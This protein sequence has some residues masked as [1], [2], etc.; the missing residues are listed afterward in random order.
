MTLPCATAIRDAVRRTGGLT[1]VA[2]DLQP[3]ALEHGRAAPGPGRG[4]LLLD[5]L[6]LHARGAARV[7]RCVPGPPAQP[8]GSAGLTSTCWSSPARAATRWS[9]T[10]RA[11]WRARRPRIR[12]SRSALGAP[13][14]LPRGVL[15][16][17]RRSPRYAPNPSLATTFGAAPRSAD[18]SLRVT[19]SPPAP[20]A[21]TPAGPSFSATALGS[22]GGCT[23]M[24][25]PE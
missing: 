3:S 7:H 22:V 8:R 12:P 1:V 2:T 9:L 5:V 15:A 16:A 21:L 23:R 6:P 19:S 4:A 25:A 24:N 13:A 14:R 18:I 17:A 20:W 11:A 10:A